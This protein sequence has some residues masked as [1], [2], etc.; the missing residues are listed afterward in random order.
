MCVYVCDKESVLCEKLRVRKT[1]WRVYFNTLLNDIIL[2][3]FNIRPKNHDRWLPSTLFSN[4]SYTK[5]LVYIIRWHCLRLQTANRNNRNNRY[6]QLIPSTRLCW[7]QCY[8]F[9]W[10][11]NYKHLREYTDYALESRR[12]QRSNGVSLTSRF[13][14]PLCTAFDKTIMIM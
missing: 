7:L 8:T 14:S 9:D 12:G 11:T 4:R 13:V 10:I 3:Q 6:C 2:L 5:N 1:I